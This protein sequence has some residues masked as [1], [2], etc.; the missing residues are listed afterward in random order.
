MSDLFN[1][2]LI[3]SLADLAIF[4]EFTNEDLLDADIAVGAMEQLAKELQCMSEEDQRI[5][6]RRLRDLRTEYPD[7]KKAQFVENLPESLGLAP[8][9]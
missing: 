6:A 1:K 8:T 4:L 5:L 7:E 3:K 2:H 9:S